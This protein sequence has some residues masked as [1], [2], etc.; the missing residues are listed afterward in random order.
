VLLWELKLFRGRIKFGSSDLK[1]KL[2]ENATKKDLEIKRNLV[3]IFRTDWEG[4][5]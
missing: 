2:K 3:Q 5:E 1:F 4:K